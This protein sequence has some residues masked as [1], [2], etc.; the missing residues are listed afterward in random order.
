MTANLQTGGDSPR[1]RGKRRS[2][3]TFGRAQ[4]GAAAIEFGIVA[5]PFFALL[6]AIFETALMFWTNEV[7]EE[8]LSQASRRLLTG[9][10]V[11]RYTSSNPAVNAQAFRDDICAVAPMG[12]IDC[13]K[14]Y[15]DVKVYTNFAGATSGTSNPV[16]NGA[17]NTNG[18]SYNQPQPGQIVVARAV[19]DYHLFLTAWASSA[20][21]N[22]GSGH[23]ALVA[24]TTFRAEPFTTG[25]GAGT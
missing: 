15:V 20:L 16:A 1:R 18:F 24:T 23:R 25:S 13:S 12:L 6:F 10:A 21:A 5:V 8:S 9:Q 22:I 17:L 14:L 2:L 19:L 3:L 7:L 4:E 11:S